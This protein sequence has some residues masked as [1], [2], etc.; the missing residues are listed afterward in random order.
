MSTAEA[1]DVAW[2]LVAAALVMFMQAGFSLLESGSVRTK[3]SINVAA[4]NFADFCLTAAVF[5]VFG[6]ALMF[7]DSVSGWFGAS[8][9][10]F[11]DT[12][13]ALLMAFFIFQIGFAGTATTIMSGA[14]AERMKF[15]GYLI[16]ALVM[17]AVIYPVY[18]HWA[19]GSLAG[20][21]AGW[22]ESLGFLDFAGSTVVHSIGGWMA[23]AGV[24]I[25]GPRLGRFGKNSVPIRGHDLPIVTLGVFILWFGWFG[26]NGGSTL[27]LTNEVP[28]I[29]V[30]TTISGAFGGL[31][32]MAISWRMGG[33]VD[34][35]TMMNGSLAGLV[36][37][38][39]SANIVSPADSAII[40]GIAGVVMYGVTALLE[41]VEIDDVVGAVPV[42]LGAGIW[43]TLAV[44]LF[45]NPEAWGGD[46]RL[47]QLGVQ[48]TGVAAAF[49]WGFGLGFL[50]LWLVNRRF[51]LRVDPDGERIGLNVAEHGAS[52]EI[53]DLLT[54]MDKQ[55]QTDDYSTPIAVEPHTE[56]GQIA[57]QYNRVLE[58]I[59]VQ[60]AALRLLRNTASAANEAQSV[61]EAMRTSVREVC[62]ATGWPVGHAY[63]VDEADPDL[64]VPTDIWRLVDPERHG[65][66][67]TATD[68]TVFHIGE[69]NPGRVLASMRP[70][71]FDVATVDPGLP[72]TQVA[73]AVGLQ[74]GIAFPVLAGTEVAAVLEFFSEEPIAPDEGLLEVMGAVGTQLGRVVERT[75]SEGAR[76]Q[77]VV[78]NMPAM[79]L[80]R[81]VDG[82]FI[83]VNRRYEDFYRLSNEDLRG[84]TL[85]EADELTDLD[86]QAKVNMAHDLEVLDR[87]RAV[88]QE[89]TIRRGV[90]EHVIASVRF[91]IADHAGNTVA[92]GGIE[93]DITERKHAEAEL[94]T[95]ADKMAVSET[96]FRSLFEDS[97][98]S[99]WEEDYSQVRIALDEVMQSGVTDLRKHF[100]EHPGLAVEFGGL[101]QVVN[102]NQATLDLYGARTKDEL[103]GSLELVLGEASDPEIADQLATF[104]E[105]HHRFESE[106]TLF[107]LNGET[108]VSLVSVSIAPGSEESWSRVFVSVVDV[109]DRKEMERLLEEA[110]R[111]AEQANQ[112]KST[113]L[114]NMS[115]ELRTPMN[116]I[117]GYSELLT[118]DAED[119]GYEELVPDLERIN[120]AGKHLLSL[121][122]DVLDLSKIEAGHMDLFL[123]TFELERELNEVVTTARPMIEKNGNEFVED[124]G[125][126][127][128]EMHADLTKVRQALFNLISNAAKFTTEGSITLR[129][130]RV[131]RDGEPW[132]SMAV[133]DTGIGIPEDK[134][135]LVFEEFAQ[136]DD[137]TTRDFGGTGLG[138]ALTRQ[139]CRM[140]G[141][142][143]GLESE[144]GVGS[145]FTITLPASVSESEDDG[146]GEP[147]DNEV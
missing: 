21:E 71:W 101:I 36:A 66:F 111:A 55:R 39:A 61:D 99:L 2:I 57:Q 81:D 79:V 132:I 44:A 45:G 102:V 33:H 84:K 54:D 118:E 116:A 139:I 70:A 34:V 68:E 56:I 25:I 128:G 120:S 113:F 77:T 83:L 107:R 19:W 35:A 38:T 141:G 122:N 80:L 123:E 8:D 72:R 75:R 119:D 14:V 85:I 129:A 69:G 31:V 50:L 4:K 133:T 18:G 90:R 93:L 13:S 137:S 43:G 40:G 48:A 20:G 130:R 134:L 76:F 67:R 10:F 65:P 138:L 114:A 29:I 104:A 27:A 1:L 115:H 106:T 108:G 97:P 95:M 9:L 51:P 28:T 58:G 131:S 117:I 24:I 98:L 125:D 12:T 143:I 23:L 16:M 109:T 74:T 47:S 17:S 32:A 121:I 63:L 103:L 73:Q 53:L 42:H 22:L 145:T 144:F 86:M 96:R 52:T 136:V 15:S 91:P 5:W 124:Y 105:G 11:S 62:A 89:L 112:A 147:A 82:R 140:M 46:G 41:R 110:M 94:A 6:Y 78:D 7:G 64:L 92:V 26:F 3:N 87:N 30:N 146:L 60:T 126:D 142:E 49:V 37:V 100:R 127:L 88:E 59:N 135:D